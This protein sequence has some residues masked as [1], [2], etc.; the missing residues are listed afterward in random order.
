MKTI[1]VVDPPKN[2]KNADITNHNLEGYNP[3]ELE[4]II[5]SI[6]AFSEIEV[7]SDLKKFTKNIKKFK[8]CIVFPMFWGKCSHIT[9]GNVPSICEANEIDYIGPDSY[10]CLLCNDKYMSKKYMQEFDLK[11]SR[12]ILIFPKEKDDTILRMLSLLKYPLVIKPNFGGGST[13]ISNKNFVKNSEEALYMIHQL[14]ENKFGPLIIEEFVE[15]YEVSLL[16]VGN[17][18]SINV[19]EETQVIVG[20]KSYFKDSLWALEDKKVDFL[21]SHYVSVKMIPEK[22]VMNSIKL[23]Q[24]FKKVEYMRIDGRINDNGFYVLEL[25]PDCYMGP[26]CDFSI[27]L[28]KHGYSYNDFMKL[29]FDNHFS[30]NNKGIPQ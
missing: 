11:T 5:N 6:S 1:L 21:N 24:S 28:E 26:N 23:F 19:Q 29:I 9:K 18:N 8:D 20:E 13:G 12:S 2:L 4:G 10:T 15:G 16:L 7:Y 3:K 25:T 22:D 14:F 27:A 17:N 30:S